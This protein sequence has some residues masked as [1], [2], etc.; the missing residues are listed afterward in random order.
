MKVRGLDKRQ[1]VNIRFRLISCL[2]QSSNANKF[3]NVF[4]FVTC[5]TI[6]NLWNF[7]LLREESRD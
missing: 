7:S 2:H 4:M 1:A 3:K 6:S 5:L